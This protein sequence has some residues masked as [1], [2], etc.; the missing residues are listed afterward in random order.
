MGKTAFRYLCALLAILFASCSKEGPL[1]KM[2]H[3]K[4][5]GNDHP[6]QALAMLDSLE[7]EARRGSV[8][9]QKKYDLLHIRLSDKA[10]IL[11]KSDAK[12]KELV[13]YFGKKG[14]DQ[15]KQEVYYYAGSVY[16]DLQDCPRAL[17]YFY[18]STDFAIGHPDCDSIMLRNTYSNLNFLQY[19][20]QN[21]KEALAMSKEELRIS[22]EL[23]TEDVVDHMHVGAAYKATG[24]AKEAVKEYDKAFHIADT[25]KDQSAY[26]ESYIR[27]L[28]DYSGLGEIK[29]AQR[30]R[31]LIKEVLNPYFSVLKDQAL[32]HYYMA[33]GKRDSAIIYS[34]RI[35]DN[36]KDQNNMYDAAKQLFRL[37]E[38]QGDVVNAHRYAVLYMQLGDTLDFGRR[39]EQAA[40]LT[41][42]YKYHMDQK[43]EM[44]LRDEKEMYARTLFVSI[45]VF[46]LLGAG[47]AIVFIHRRNVHLRKMLELSERIEQMAHNEQELRKEM[48]R[49]EVELRR[50]EG[51]LGAYEERSGEHPGRAGQG[52]RQTDCPRRHTAGDRKNAGREDKGGKD[53]PA[54]APPVEA[55]GELGGRGPQVQEGGIGRGGAD[56]RRLGPALPRRGPGIS[57]V[58]RGPARQVGRSHQAAK[59]GML[60]IKVWHVQESDTVPHPCLAR[61]DLALGEEI[62]L[63]PGGGGTLAWRGGR[64]RHRRRMRSQDGQVTPLYCFS[65]S[66]SFKISTAS[67]T[68]ATCETTID[69]FPFFSFR[70]Q[71]RGW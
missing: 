36:G 24:N 65:S 14:S 16:R 9:A 55:R 57:F 44:E 2:E 15:E 18:K 51:G 46:T 59:A 21:Y 13:E 41:N 53:V 54:A 67:F 68:E 43:K 40:T 12:I 39:Q 3:I 30:C 17:E 25:T 20:V 8:Y 61:H 35:I 69:R 23:G 37:Y 66:M 26:Q 19:R 33:C 47:G 5:V 29:K 27:L 62:R 42:A 38:E 45:F 60:P 52:Q 32:A 70:L 34:Q 7:Q 11:P 6:K 64:G 71:R 56:Q 49:K 28:M 31:P 58:C 63:G 22:K 48:E 10:N 4:M 1:D 50:V